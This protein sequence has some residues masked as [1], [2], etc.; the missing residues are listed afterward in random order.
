[1]NPYNYIPFSITHVICVLLFVDVDGRIECTL[2]IDVVASVVKAMNLHQNMRYEI[3]NRPESVHFSCNSF[4]C[5]FVFFDV[6]SG[7]SNEHKSNNRSYEIVNTDQSL[8][9]F[10]IV[11]IVCVF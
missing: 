7:Q 4:F 9:P 3:V 6:E 10:S 1:M 2:M 11:H 5:V 8:F